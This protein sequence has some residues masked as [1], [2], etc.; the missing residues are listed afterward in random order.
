MT[1]LYRWTDDYNKLVSERM[2]SEHQL[3][4]L[5]EQLVFERE[6]NAR[7]R[8]EWEYLEKIQDDVNDQLTK[9]E[10]ANM[11]QEIR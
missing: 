8:E 2:R 4:T 3:C 5:Q 6:K 10:F 11:V 1:N 7:C 9:K